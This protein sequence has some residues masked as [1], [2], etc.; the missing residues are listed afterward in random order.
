MKIE[1]LEEEYLLEV[2]VGTSRLRYRSLMGTSKRKTALIGYKPLKGSLNLR[3]I[4]MKR[5]LGWLFS[6]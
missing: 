6:S 2:I 1:E 4:M 3:S 5:P